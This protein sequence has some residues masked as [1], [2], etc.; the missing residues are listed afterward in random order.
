MEPFVFILPIAAILAVVFFFILCRNALRGRGMLL[1]VDPD[2]SGESAAFPTRRGRME[3]KDA[4]PLMLLTAVYAFVGF[5]GLGDKDAP[6]RFCYFA[7]EGNYALIELKEPT[8]ISQILYYTG[9]HTGNYYL[10]YSLDGE[11]WTDIAVLEQTYSDL[12]KWLYAELPEGEQPVTKYVRLISDAELELG[13]LALFDGEGGRIAPEDMVYDAG[14]DP[15][16]DEQETVPDE[17]TYL[18]STYFDEIYH[19]RTAY[20]N[21]RDV[22]PYEVSH[23]PLGKLIISVG[24]RLFGMTPFGWRFMGTLFGVI[25][26]PFLYIFLKNLFGVTAIAA[27]GTAIFA[28]DFMHYTQTRIA[29]IDTYAVIFILIAYF[30]FYR[31]LTVDRDDPLLPKWRYRLPL[32][33]SGIFWGIGCASKW[34]VIYAGAG[35]GLLWLLYWIFRG[36]GLT[37]AGRW[38]T[39]LRELGG[40]IPFCLVFFL[41]VPCVIYYVS[42]Y[43]YGHARGMEGLGMFFQ[44]EYLDIVL[45]NQEFMFTYHNGVSSPHPYASRWYQWLVDARPILYYLES[46]D[47]GT[48]SAFAAFLNP[49]LCWGGLLAMFAMGYR[50]FAKK[51]KKALFILVGYLS[52]LLPWLPISRPTFAYHYFPCVIFLTLALSHVFNLIRISSVRWRHMVYGYTAACVALF[53]AFYP[54]LSGLRVPTWYSDLLAWFP[55]WPF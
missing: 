38:R 48:K 25:M 33:L 55:S 3:K 9:L 7:D 20:E 39:L 40:N 53:V 14:C 10:Q 43:P 51:D 47:D 42:Y 6:Q 11:A 4:L 31:F 35:L 49:L 21:V 36:R 28:F 46:Y 52:Q 24:I 15:L 16:F 2:F 54:V 50:T 18:N 1:Y 27:C 13:E 19:A 26:L 37:R 29:T 45:D 17:P 5:F 32:A 41:L 30:F 23:P 8:Q 22:Y 44:K 12:F 34:T